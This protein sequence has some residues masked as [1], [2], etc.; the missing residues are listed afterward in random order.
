MKK[1]LL[2]VLIG[3]IFLTLAAC[4]SREEAFPEYAFQATVLEVTETHLLVEPVEGS[5][6]R[7]CSD[8]MVIV[9]EGRPVWPLP[10]EGDLVEICYDGMI[11][12]LYPARIPNPIRVE[13]RESS[14]ELPSV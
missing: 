4:G 3:S 5:R 13:L 9:L 11:Q 14:N 2:F 8:K 1:A 10:R 7:D 12:E 6:E